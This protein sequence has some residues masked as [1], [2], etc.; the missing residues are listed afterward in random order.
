MGFQ[1]FL[2]KV[3]NVCKKRYRDSDIIKFSFDKIVR[4]FMRKQ[5][6]G[7]FLL[8]AIIIFSFF[9]VIIHGY[10]CSSVSSARRAVA[11]D[12]YLWRTVAVL[13]T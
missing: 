11:V 9:A 6:L 12:S 4:K 8:V 1:L 5:I 10:T 13:D 2:L 3:F 7:I